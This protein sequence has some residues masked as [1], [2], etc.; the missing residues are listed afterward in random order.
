MV[1]GGAGRSLH[2]QDPRALD[3]RLLDHRHVQIGAAAGLRAYVDAGRLQGGQRGQA[4]PGAPQGSGRQQ[5]AARGVDEIMDRAIRRTHEALDPDEIETGLG[6]LVPGP[7]CFVC[8]SGE[9][10]ARGREPQ[11]QTIVGVGRRL[12]R[13]LRR[14]GPALAPELGP[15][16]SR[17]GG[18]GTKL[19]GRGQAALALHV[20]AAA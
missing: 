8:L 2:Q 6:D 12:L 17:R 11:R 15:A 10:A 19:R 13:Q 3:P 7:E 16:I 9:E 18:T 20:P 4:T 5:L 14:L 1:G